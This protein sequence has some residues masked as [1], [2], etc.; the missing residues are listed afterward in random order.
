MKILVFTTLFPN[1]VWP[2]N[3]VFVKERMAHVARIEGCEVKVVAP[4][5][6]FPKINLGWRA[7]YLQ[8]KSRE[9]IDGLEVLHP[10]YFMTPKLGMA[11]Y[12]WMMFLSVLR[13]VIQLRRTFHFDLIDSHYVYPDGFAAVLLGQWFRKP[14]VVSARGSDVNRYAELAAIKPLLRYTMTKADKVIAVSGAMKNAIVSL[15]ID[16]RKVSVIPN[17][18]DC[19]KFYPAS[20]CWARARIGLSENVKVILSAGRLVPVKGFDLLIRAFKMLVDGGMGENLNLII[21]GD[22]RERQ[23]LQSLI[24][25]LQL[26]THVRLAGVVPHADLNVW[27]NAA[28]VFCL[29]SRREGW[30]NVILESIACGTP[31]VATAVGGIPEIIRSNSIGFLTEREVPEVA[32]TLGRALGTNWRREEIVQYARELTWEKTAGAVL[33]V[34]HHVIMQQRRP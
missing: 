23:R 24:A 17:G 1:N 15:G 14:V 13:A 27:Y 16:E 9:I 10:R 19:R 31:V 21:V 7:A 5:P 22:G 33:D 18:V 25:E 6:Y 29:C 11:L 20:K 28:D 30:P 3:N 4:V 12:G 8:V 34:F 2:N 32:A 26:E